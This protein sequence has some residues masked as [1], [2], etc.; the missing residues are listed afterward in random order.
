M[1]FEKKKMWSKS[2][3]TGRRSPP[4]GSATHHG[5]QGE[6]RGEK[7]GLICSR[8]ALALQANRHFRNYTHKRLQILLSRVTLAKKRRRGK[9]CVINSRP[10]RL[11]HR[12]KCARAL[13]G[14]AISYSQTRV[15]RVKGGIHRI[16]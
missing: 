8:K 13:L 14:G 1:K 6:G 9:S 16:E 12:G 15:N 3:R 2:R 10:K 5:K 7:R 4:R 11:G